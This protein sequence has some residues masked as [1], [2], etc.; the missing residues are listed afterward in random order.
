M[1]CQYCQT[2]EAS[3][4]NFD[5]YG[6]YHVCCFCHVARGFPVDPNHLNCLKAQRR[7]ADQSWKGIE[8]EAYRPQG[9]PCTP[10]ETARIKRALDLFDEHKE[11]YFSGHELD[12][13]QRTAVINLLFRMQEREHAFYEIKVN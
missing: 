9:D 8:P 7:I 11:R 13:I 12:H 10:N 5:D 2:R 6:N 1:K 4:E 3:H